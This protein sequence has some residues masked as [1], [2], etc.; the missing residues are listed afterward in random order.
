MFGEQSTGVEKC[1]DAGYVSEFQESQ[2]DGHPLVI[3]C[4]D[5]AH[6]AL[7]TSAEAKSS[8]P[9]STSCQTSP[10]PEARTSKKSSTCSTPRLPIVDRHAPAACR[11]SRS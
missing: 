5:T 9:A 1:P 6:L 8:S 3:G 4:R 11:P 2:V 7:S 10:S